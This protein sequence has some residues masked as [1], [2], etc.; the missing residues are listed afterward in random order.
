MSDPTFQSWR[1]KNRE[2]QSSSPDQPIWAKRISISRSLVDWGL[3]EPADT[4]PILDDTGADCRRNQ[5][6]NIWFLA[7]TFYGPPV[8]R[9]CKIPAGKALFFPIANGYQFIQNS[10]NRVISV[11]SADAST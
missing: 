6:G 1:R 2:S 10:P 9:T 11:R 5:H 8:E 3:K 4:N 7:G